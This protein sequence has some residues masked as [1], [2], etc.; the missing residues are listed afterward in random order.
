MP[1]K[2]TEEKLT[3]EQLMKIDLEQLSLEKRLRVQELTKELKERRLHYPIMDYVTM[4]HQQELV[5]AVSKRQKHKPKLPFYKF[6]MLI[7]W[8]GSGKT[9]GSVY[10]NILMALGKSWEKYWLPY[11][12][13]AKQ[14]LVVTKTSDIIKTNLEPYFL[15]KND[16]DDVI[17]IPKAEIEKVKRDWSTQALKEIILKNG[18]V[19]LFRTY[20]AW[21]SRLEGSSPDFVHLDELPEREDIFLELL[22]GTRKQN[23]QMLLSFTPTKF[24]PA[25]FNY[26]YGQESDAVRDKTFIREVDSLENTHVDHTWLEWLSDEERKIRRFGKFVPPSWLVY[27]SFNRS[28]NLVKYISPRELWQWVKYYAWLDFG[29]SHPMAFVLIAIDTDW[30]I[31]VFDMIY[32]KSLLLWDLAEMIRSKIKEYWIS[33]EYIV[34]DT[35]DKRARL[36]LEKVHNIHTQPADKWSKWETNMSNRRAGIFKI[37]ELFEKWELI[38][39]DKCMKLVQELEVHAYKGNGTED[40]IKENDDA[41]DALRYFIFSQKKQDNTNNYKKQIKKINKKKRTKIRY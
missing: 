23:S 31:Y 36:E 7:G 32:Q 33:L 10:I 35:A 17:K 2:K 20:D 14:I 27:N 5:D 15:W 19:I 22:R 1:K 8:N 13:E 28:N 12:G 11:I 34:A 16:L 26:F 25:V 24:N 6:I 29:T 30:H 21:Q 37:N 9:C 38:I 3:Y 4:E 41:I 40:V 39:S 18:T